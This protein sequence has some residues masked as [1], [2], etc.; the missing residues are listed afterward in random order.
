MG[1]HGAGR[2]GVSERASNDGAGEPIVGIGARVLTWANQLYC[3]LHGHNHLK[4]FTKRR[5]FLE[6]AS[7]GYESPGWTLPNSSPKL[8]ARGDARRHRLVVR[9]RLADTRRIA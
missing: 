4:R 8:V 5:V 1:T 3:G 7:C 9:P 6:C 2:I